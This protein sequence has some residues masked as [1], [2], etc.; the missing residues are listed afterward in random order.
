MPPGPDS[1]SLTA[2]LVSIAFVCILAFLI[3][4]GAAA[5]RASLQRASPADLRRG[6]D[7]APSSWDSTLHTPAPGSPE[8]D[9]QKG[10]EIVVEE[11]EM[12]ADEIGGGLP[13][14]TPASAEGRV[15][16]AAGSDMWWLV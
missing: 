13:L 5:Y 6:G 2:P 16:M 7:G 10:V 8:K 4:L 14:P 15:S 11:V 1:T 12:S 3:G 9:L